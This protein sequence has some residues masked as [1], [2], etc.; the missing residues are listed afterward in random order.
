M[1][2]SSTPVAPS[3]VT[4]ALARDRLGAFTIGAAI[5]SSVAPLTVVALVVSSAVAVTGLLGFPLAIVAV[6]LILLI[7]VVG[8]LAMARH[9]PN[10]GAFYAYVAHGVGRPFGVGTSWVALATYT[11]FQLCCYGGL[12]AIGAPLLKAWFGVGVPWYVLA[13]AAWVLVAVLGANEVK[14]S[15]LVLMVLVIAETVLVVLDSVAIALTPGFHFSAAAVS[16]GN[17]TGPMLG[18]LIV[19]GATSFAGVEQAA[20][21]I[22]ESKDPRRTIP[23]ATYGTIVIIATVY[24]LASWVQISAGGP[25]IIDRAAAEGGDLFFNQAAVQLGAA[26]VHLGHLLLGTGLIAALLAFHQAIARYTF[27]L[28]RE[29]VLPRPF[30]H[31]TIKGAP[32][33]ASLAQTVIAFLALTLYAIAG[34]DPLIQLFYLGST[35]GGLGV[36]LLYTMTSIAV[37]AFFART[38]HG[39]WLWQ[40]RIAPL[41]ATMVLMVVSYLAIDNLAALY[42]VAPGTGP[43]QIVP[44]ALLTI[45]VA[46]TGYGLLLKHSKPAV[47][48]GIGRGARSETATKSGLS[49]IF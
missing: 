35:T 22:E 42:G 14:V 39:E 5:A 26:A 37:L 48:E 34:W 32:R 47:Y 11:S 17:L 9:I 7:F 43:A 10:A 6:A 20:V 2:A 21:Y 3:S 41:I 40:R 38:T 30:G 27:A 24:A 29:G 12:G 23:V 44:I 33:N 15:G 49:A 19:L 4:H 28:G 25:K 46:G 13:Y 8:Y 36:L 1:P 18:V 16:P 31:T 45:F